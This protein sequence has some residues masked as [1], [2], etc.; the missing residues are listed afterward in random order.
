V[1]LGWMR[2]NQ[3]RTDKHIDTTAGELEVWGKRP[4][5]TSIDTFTRED[6]NATLE[7]L[8]RGELTGRY[9]NARDK[10]GNNI[11]RPD[12]TPEQVRLKTKPP[13]RSTRN[14]YL[15]ALTKF[16]NWARDND[17]A[18]NLA[19][20]KVHQLKEPK[21][22]AS[23][24]PV[25][26]PDWRAVEKLLIPKWAL[27]QTVLLGSGMRYG[28]LAAMQDRY[29]HESDVGG[30]SNRI[31]DSKQRVGRIVPVS[32]TVFDAAKELVKL[33][34]ERVTP[35]AKVKK[36]PGE[37][38]RTYPP[39]DEGSQMDKRL[40]SA[41][42]RADVRRYTVH[43]MRHTYATGCLMQGMNLL[44]LQRRMGHADLETTEAY[45]HVAEAIK[46]DVKLYAPV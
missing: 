9:R 32:K 35:G 26:T 39:N 4:G 19:D 46:G 12:G 8:G 14:R 28:E 3:R 5:F 33:P 11:L 27:A 40:A 44:E 6:I 23:K 21:K 24:F 2:D 25:P 10:D 17:R 43:Q 13:G 34:R 37:A 30:C 42:R 36:K 41:C 18:T 20:T 45:L 15:A 29:L 1:F 38:D 7:A 22:K 31:P 16:M